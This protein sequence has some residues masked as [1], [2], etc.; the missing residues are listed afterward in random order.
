M[1]ITAVSILRCGSWV[2]SEGTGACD[3][4]VNM[5][6]TKRPLEGLTKRDILRISFCSTGTLGVGANLY[7]RRYILI[8]SESRHVKA[9][10]QRIDELLTNRMPNITEL[11]Q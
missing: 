5:A 8:G 2:C 7:S 9:A 6:V 10:R 1:Y 4:E 11:N 3:A